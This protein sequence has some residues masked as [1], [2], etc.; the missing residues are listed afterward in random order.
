MC[1]GTE[2]KLFWKDTEK[3]INSGLPQ[4]EELEGQGDSFHFTLLLLF[5]FF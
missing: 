2:R 3:M 4:G 5:E 1:T